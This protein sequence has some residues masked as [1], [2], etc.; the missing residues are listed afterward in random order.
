MN[1]HAL[2]TYIRQ[3]TRFI[4]LVNIL[5]RCLMTFTPH[6]L[7]YKTNER[8]VMSFNTIVFTHYQQLARPTDLE[9][10]Q[11]S[12]ASLMVRKIHSL[13]TLSM[14]PANFSLWITFHLGLAIANCNQAMKRLSK[15][16]NISSIMFKNEILES[17]TC[18]FLETNFLC[19][20]SSARIPEES[21][22][23]TPNTWSET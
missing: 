1:G 16:R 19:I 6:L 21:M 22:L 8:L 10:R 14:N 17:V 18:M 12:T 20:S 2:G 13:P 9:Q 23:I 4:I 3:H 15:D 5:A 11:A 7:T